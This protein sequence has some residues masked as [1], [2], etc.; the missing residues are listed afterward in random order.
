[1]KK[2]LGTIGIVTSL[3]IGAFALN[4]VLPASA[5]TLATQ[6]TQVTQAEQQSGD[7]SQCS[8][9]TTVTDVLD[10]L[11]QDGTI[12]SDQ[13][14]AIVDAL[15]AARESNDSNRPG[16]GRRGIRERA[17]RGALQVA[18]DKIGVSVDDLKAAVQGG[19]SIADVATAHNVAPAD[20]QQAIIDAATARIDQAVTNGRLTDERATALKNRL[21]QMVERV[22]NHKGTC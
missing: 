8:N 15:K 5:G 13:E 21:P 11:V 7:G 10:K 16:A 1:M 19:Q 22:V 14:S 12:N 9:R 6:V 2:L 3:G 4:S 20:V 17:V 18:A